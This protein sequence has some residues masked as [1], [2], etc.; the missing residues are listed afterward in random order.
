MPS[1]DFIITKIIATLGPASSGKAAILKL[2]EAGVRVFRINFSHGAFEDY[3]KLVKDIRAVQKKSGIY[4]SILGDLS[5]P[6]IRVGKV[7]EGGVLL[8]KGDEI[9]FIKEEI[10]GGAD[11]YEKTFS[12]TLPLFIDEVKKAEKILLDDGNIELKCIRT[13]GKGKEAILHC[14]VIVG[15]LLSSA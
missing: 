3:D 13:T 9:C 1:T 4:V 15:N 2:V 14:K 10:I 12:S 11:G 6:K 8:K 7:I 5:G